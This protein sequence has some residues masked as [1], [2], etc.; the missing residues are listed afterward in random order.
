MSLQAPALDEF[1]HLLGAEHGL[2]VMD[3]V[4]DDD[5]VSLIGRVGVL[6]LLDVQDLKDHRA[7]RRV[8]GVDY[9]LDRAAV[10]LGHFAQLGQKLPYL[11]GGGSAP[12]L[13]PYLLFLSFDNYKFRF[14][15]TKFLKYSSTGIY[16]IICV[17][18]TPHT[19]GHVTLGPS[20]E[21]RSVVSHAGRSVLILS[22]SLSLPTTQTKKGLYSATAPAEVGERPALTAAV[23]HSARPRPWSPSAALLSN[24]SQNPSRSNAR[25]PLCHA[26]VSLRWCRAYGPQFAVEGSLNINFYML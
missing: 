25:A 15:G 17:F 5:T 14:H 19:A 13:L 16:R 20:Q 4:R 2:L 23:A 24:A 9:L 21:T 26:S 8:A 11:F 12:E 3:T 1:V 10:E 18:L 7:Q 22:L 6:D